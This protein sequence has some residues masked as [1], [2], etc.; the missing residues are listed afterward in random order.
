MAEWKIWFSFL[1]VN[2]KITKNEKSYF[3]PRLSFILYTVVKIVPSPFNAQNYMTQTMNSNQLSNRLWKLLLHTIPSQLHLP[4]RPLWPRSIS[5]SLYLC[6]LI[7]IVLSGSLTF[8]HIDIVVVVVVIDVRVWKWAVSFPE[9]TTQQSVGENILSCMRQ[10]WGLFKQQPLLIVY[11]KTHTLLD[12]NRSFFDRIKWPYIMKRRPTKTLNEW[13][14][15]KKNPMPTT[16]KCVRPI[17]L[18]ESAD[19]NI[20]CNTDRRRISS[21]SGIYLLQKLLQLNSKLWSIAIISFDQ[22]LLFNRPDPV[23]YVNR[24]NFFFLLL[25]HF[26]FVSSF[27]LAIDAMWGSFFYVH[28]FIFSC[29]FRQWTK[30]DLTICHWNPYAVARIIQEEAFVKNGHQMHEG[31][32]LCNRFVNE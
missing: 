18:I 21:R 5:L 12:V 7:L 17:S 24:S 15:R 6:F 1:S 8:D 14:A 25:L 9:W 29:S 32:M 16:Q 13:R 27:H 26:S 30:F 10:W 28:I 22:Y 23:V 19:I 4:K 3:D 31:C 20:V 11:S 2:G